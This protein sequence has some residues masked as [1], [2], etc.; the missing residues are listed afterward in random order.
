MLFNHYYFVL[1]DFLCIFEQNQIIYK[2]KQNGKEQKSKKRG[3]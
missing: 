2:S 3:Q 1:T